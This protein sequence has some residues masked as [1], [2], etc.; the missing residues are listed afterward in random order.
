MH[1]DYIKCFYDQPLDRQWT[2]ILCPTQCTYNKVGNYIYMSRIAMF[3]LPKRCRTWVTKN[4]W[5][6]MN[7]VLH[8]KSKEH[9]GPYMQLWNSCE[10][11]AYMNAMTKKCFIMHKEISGNLMNARECTKFVKKFIEAFY[12][13]PPMHYE[14]QRMPMVWNGT[15]YPSRSS[16]YRKWATIQQFQTNY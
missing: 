10:R 15:N 4:I 1:A 8:L 9:K 16:K 3:N 6:C 12:L 5:K 11:C 13:T 2:I 7:L 14:T